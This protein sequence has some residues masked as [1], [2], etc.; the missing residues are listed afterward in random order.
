MIGVKIPDVK[1]PGLFIK[2]PIIDTTIGHELF[3]SAIRCDVLEAYSFK[4]QVIMYKP[5]RLNPAYMN[6]S[7]SELKEIFD[8]IKTSNEIALAKAKS[9][10]KK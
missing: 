1:I 8:E 7:A 9:I 4:D 3:D 10:L 6:Y 2:D 5:N